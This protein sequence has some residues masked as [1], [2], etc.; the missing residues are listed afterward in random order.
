MNTLSHKWKLLLFILLVTAGIG[1]RLVTEVRKICMTN[2][3]LAR[4]ADVNG[5]VDSIT[6]DRRG[7]YLSYHYPSAGAT[8][9][10]RDRCPYYRH[11]ELSLPKPGDIIPIRIHPDLPQFALSRYSLYY[12]Y[13]RYVPLAS[14]VLLLALVMA[15]GSAR[16]YPKWWARKL[17]FGSGKIDGLARRSIKDEALRQAIAKAEALG[18]DVLGWGPDLVLQYEDEDVK[19]KIVSELAKDGWHPREDAEDAQ[20]NILT[21]T[22]KAKA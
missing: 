11:W 7:F 3:A 8:F 12:G 16:I 14:W 6:R 10:R 13:K 18:G 17:R 9:Q 4:G 21:F 1:S 20:A 2:A 15:L 22:R 19:S 5:I